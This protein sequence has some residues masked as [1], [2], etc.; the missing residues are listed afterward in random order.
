MTRK[1]RSG[2]KKNGDVFCMQFL[3]IIQ[4][5]LSSLPKSY[6]PHQWNV[7]CSSTVANRYCCCLLSRA[8][9]NQDLSRLEQTGIS[10]SITFNQARLH[11][12][13]GALSATRNHR[14]DAIADDRQFRRWLLVLIWSKQPCNHLNDISIF[15]PTPKAVRTMLVYIYFRRTMI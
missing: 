7:A 1:V 10:T 13:G 2:P 8:P 5:N 11:F 15:P 6:T 9:E 3:S 4:K 12:K 14:S